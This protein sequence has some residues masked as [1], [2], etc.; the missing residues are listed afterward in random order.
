MAAARDLHVIAVCS[1]PVG[2]ASRYRL[3]RPFVAEMERAGVHLVIVE[4]AF[5]ERDFAVTHGHN[6]DH[7]QFRGR[8]GYEIWLKESLI[9]AGFRHLT[10]TAPNWRKAAWIDADVS[11]IRPDWAEATLEA[12]DHYAV[13]QPWSYSI[14]L[15]PRFEPMANEWGNDVD[16]SF[17][18]AFAAG[19]FRGGWPYADSA[20]GDADTRYHCGYAWAIRREAYE[21]I[22]GLIDWM[23]TG[24]ADFHM[25]LAFGGMLRSHVAKHES[26]RSA[27]YLRRLEEF[28]ARCDQHVRG[29]VG[30]AAGL[31][32]HNF[33]GYKAKRGYFTADHILAETAFDPDHDLERDRFGIQRLT[34]AKPR[35]AQAIRSWF[36]QR[37]EDAR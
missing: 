28:A 6:R 27:G 11:F 31:I 25:A 33:H 37:D 8:E 14:D 15:G 9:N 22:G 32:C 4:H 16:R 3:F 18:R 20:A 1:N 24:S 21:A 26:G 10:A 23:P 30:Y 13:V 34:G 5:A 29:A 35:L 19:V 12:L 2:W 17:G 7:L 36:R